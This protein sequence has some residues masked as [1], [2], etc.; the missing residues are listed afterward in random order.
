MNLAKLDYKWLVG[1]VYVL[2][3][4]M[5]LLDMTIIT[6]AVPT[7]A[8]TFHASTTTIEWVVTGYLLSLAVF[9]P[10]SGWLGDRFGTKRTFITALAIFLAGSILCGLAWD[11][12]SLIA[13]RVLQGVGGGMLTP[14]RHGDAVPRLPAVRARRRFRRPRHPDH[15]RP[16]PRAAARRLPGRLRRSGAGSS[17]STSPSASSPS[18]PPPPCC[19]RKSRAASAGWTCPASRSRPPAS[20]PSSTPSPRPASTASATVASCSSAASASPCSR[21]SP[22]WSCAPASR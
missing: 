16:G 2:A 4:F 10:I 13:F 1:I 7:L 17:S 9:I 8:Q 22:S 5:D 21:R 20:P 18:S 19:A 11:I 6:V 14:G 12:D 15:R 3:L